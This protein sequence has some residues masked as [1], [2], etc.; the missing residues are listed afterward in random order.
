M[1]AEQLD[2]A[3]SRYRARKSMRRGHAAMTKPGWFDDWLWT[4]C[5]HDALRA[6]PTWGAAPQPPGDPGSSERQPRAAFGKVSKP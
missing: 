4:E 6:V 3:W 5:V 1:T 2:Y